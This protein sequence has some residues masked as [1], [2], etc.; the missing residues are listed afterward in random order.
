MHLIPLYGIW[1]CARVIPHAW[2]VCQD[3]FMDDSKWFLLS[4]RSVIVSWYPSQSINFIAVDSNCHV[5][6]IAS[7]ELPVIKEN[8][9]QTIPSE[10]DVFD[11]LYPWDTLN[12]HT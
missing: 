11:Q 9:Y 1:I 5:T 4:L 8:L 7:E 10:I 12:T 6:T 2:L 3:H